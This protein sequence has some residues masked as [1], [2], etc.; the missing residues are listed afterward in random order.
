M[1][2]AALLPVLLGL[3][4]TYPV[5]RF[6][7]LP[8]V[9]AFGPELAMLPGDGPG[10]GVAIGNTLRLATLSALCALPPAVWFGMLLERRAWAGRRALAGTLLL[11]FLLPGYLVAAGWQI[12]LDAPAL[13]ALP[14]LRDGLLGWP[15]LVGLTALKGLPVA[16]LALRTGWIAR[17][18]RLDDATRL[19]VRSRWRRAA[20][21]IRPILPAAAAAVLIVFVE[22]TQEYGLATTLGARLRLPLLV[23]EVYASLAN[24]P[25]SW[26]RAARAADLLVLIA[27]LPVAVRL[28]F[29]GR[30]AP[31]LDRGFVTAPRRASGSERLAGYAALAAVFAAGCGVPLVALA[32][33][34]VSPDAGAL[35]TEAW[36]VVLSSLLYS[37]V[38]SLMALGL[39]CAMCAP[40]AG[41][42][43]WR[44]LGWLP[45]IN[46]A[47]PG[48][49]LGAAGVIAFNAP[50]LA[51]I[52]TPLALLL[53]QTASQLPILALFLSAPFRARGA[54]LG[55]AARVHGI[56]LLTRIERIHLPPLFRPLAWAWSLAFSRLFFELPLAQMLAPAGG[57]PVGV[58]LVQL[59]QAL[60][61]AAEARLAILAIMVCG[62]VIGATLMLAERTR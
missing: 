22:A 39:A 34:A 9:P 32:A 6:L 54:V 59:Q 4:V 62:V 17:Q 14:W 33:D 16:T 31:L 49:V 12:V 5:L 29:A 47:V 58:A 19:H 3:V 18:P 21:S 10:L 51:L 35:P 52:G 45:L 37:F 8:L 26:T 44:A 2:A 28:L 36:R 41:S 7:L 53:A 60:R 55:D 38:G 23:T 57:E 13:G 15:G 20:L 42:H 25:I 50:P 61:F 40:N 48:I 46:A 11:L 30:G 24:W 56:G 27:L 1:R 43:V